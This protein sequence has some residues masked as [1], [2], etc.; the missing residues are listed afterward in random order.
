MTME[1][2][3]DFFSI[4]SRRFDFSEKAYSSSHFVLLIFFQDH[5]E[6]YTFFQ[7]FCLR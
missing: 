7:L 4:F 3:K 1:E 5:N 6:L 2:T